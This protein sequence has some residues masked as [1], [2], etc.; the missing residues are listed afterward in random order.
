MGRGVVRFRT[1]SFENSSIFMHKILVVFLLVLLASAA[2]VPKR[3]LGC[4]NDYAPNTKAIDA[5]QGIVQDLR[6]VKLIE[7]WT[8]RRDRLRKEVES[9]GDFKTRNDLASALMHTDDATSAI[10]ILE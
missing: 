8:I 10:Q 4:I 1:C 7:P 6:T 2:V 9:G 3:L 5:S